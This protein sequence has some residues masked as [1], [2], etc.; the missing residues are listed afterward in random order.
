MSA[1]VGVRTG[2]ERVV[3]SYEVDVSQCRAIFGIAEDD[4]QEATTARTS[5]QNALTSLESGAQD[6]QLITA[7]QHLR[8]QVIVSSMDGA[9]S[10]WSTACEAGREAV[11]HVTRGD[12]EMTQNSE[13]GQQGVG[14]PDMPGVR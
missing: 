12:Q 8:D 5:A 10:R 6:H 2:E 4:H 14:R 3:V 9:M 11:G 13:S 7:I 1:E